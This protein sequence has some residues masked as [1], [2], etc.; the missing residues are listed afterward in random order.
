MFCKHCRRSKNKLHLTIVVRELG[1]QVQFFFL[2]LIAIVGSISSLFFLF[3]LCTYLQGFY[4]RTMFVYLK[5][6]YAHLIKDFL[7]NF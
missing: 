4:Q 5:T 7:C 2:W 6:Q 3:P 1:F